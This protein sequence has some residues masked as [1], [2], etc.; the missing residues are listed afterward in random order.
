MAH[1]SD[2][3]SSNADVKPANLL[4]GNDYKPEVMTLDDEDDDVQMM[5]QVI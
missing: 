5:E 2:A 1:L 3:A 4:R